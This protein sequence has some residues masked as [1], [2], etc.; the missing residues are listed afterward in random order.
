MFPFFAR[1]WF[2]VALG[3]QVGS[4]LGS[5]I[6]ILCHYGKGKTKG[7]EDRHNSAIKIDLFEY[8]K[9]PPAGESTSIFP[10]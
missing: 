3:T 7:K 5:A 9:M 4:Q 10:A 6:E 1:R 8:K 2:R